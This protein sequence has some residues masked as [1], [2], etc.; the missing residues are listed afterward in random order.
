[1]R[2]LA[3]SLGAWDTIEAGQRHRH[4]LTFPLAILAAVLAE[5]GLPA[6]DAWEG[7][8]RPTGRARDYDLLLV[9]TMDSRHFWRLPPWLREIGCP[10][11]AT[12][13]GESD[14][15]VVVGG[16]AATAPAPIEPYADVVY[17]GEAE[18]HVPDMVRTLE[19]ARVAGWSRAR[20]LDAVAA[21]PG[22]LVP[23]RRPDGHV[24]SQ[25]YAADV[26][27]TLRERISVSHRDVV[28]VEIARGCRSRCGFCALGW[29]APYRENAAADV[30]AALRAAH[31]VGTREVHLSAGD[32]EGH[33]EIVSLRGAVSALGLR[34][35]GWTGRLDTVRDCSVSAGK[36]FAFGL[37]GASHRLRRAIGK[38]RLTDDYIVEEVGAYWRAGGRRLML[39]FIGG[40][41]TESDADDD[42]LAGLLDRLAY[43]AGGIGERIHMEIGRQPFGPLP[44]TPMQWFAPGLSTERIGRVVARHVGG[45]A[46]AVTDKAGQREPEALI[47]AV[48]MRGGP[49]VAPLVECGP[50][51]MPRDP[52]FARG[53]VAG[54]LRSAGLDPERYWGAW[55]PDAPTPWAHV[56]SAHP[57]ERLR[58]Q[59]ARIRDL[60]DR[61]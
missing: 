43:V 18:A 25:V 11:R 36:Q 26:G 5:C 21:V 42:E 3:T 4:G 12:D 46:L 56:R 47:N 14:P 54:W 39:H 53:A 60:L 40:L 29:R 27:I 37:E 57:P 41:P 2:M 8:E 6:P 61:A 31:E 38:P 1:M 51:R 7:D 22:C 10:V 17:I 59:W 30:E 52:R 28:R 55:D 49:E 32:A 9:S 34:D 19:S 48:V 44:H 15:L 23:S 35:H 33:S 58:R 20:T 16:Q 24:V 13:R 45:P 50:P